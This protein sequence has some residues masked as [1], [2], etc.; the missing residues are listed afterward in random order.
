MKSKAYIPKAI[1]YA[2]GMDLESLK[3]VIAGNVTALMA[4]R[5]IP[6]EKRLGELAGVD[7]KTINN[8]VNPARHSMQPSLAVLV[9]VAT[10]LDTTVD[11]LLQ[12]LPV[13]LIANKQLDKL[14]EIFVDLN[15]DGRREVLH[16][17]E[18]EARYAPPREIGNG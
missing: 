16:V 14:E 6:T 2:T 10:A 7:Q 17:A 15:A 3:V 13:E 9:A 11:R 1:P 12:A 4:Q 8:L 5:G 18:R